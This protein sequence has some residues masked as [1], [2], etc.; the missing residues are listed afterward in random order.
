[1]KPNKWIG[2]GKSGTLS[3]DSDTDWQGFR[4][5]VYIQVTKSKEK[6]EYTNLYKPTERGKGR[7]NQHSTSG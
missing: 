4:R 2:D 5:R 6:R 3:G 7:I 1:M